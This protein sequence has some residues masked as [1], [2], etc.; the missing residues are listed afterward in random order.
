MEL[1]DTPGI[2]HA[3]SLDIQGRGLLIVGPSGSGKSALALQLIALGARL[4]SDDRTHV[5]PRD[6]Q[7]IASA[8]AT[9]EGLIEAR[10][11]G[12]LRTDSTGPT[13]LA[14]V[15]DMGNVET[16]RLPDP[17]QAH[18]CGVALPCLRR[19]EGPHFAAAL[20]LY[21]QRPHTSPP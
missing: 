5:A 9:I 13:P 16:A 8:P 10:G 2:I 15:V 1:T 3:T 18:L 14:L 20:L 7:V 11:V 21:L 4:V 12:I 17:V 19:V 6:G